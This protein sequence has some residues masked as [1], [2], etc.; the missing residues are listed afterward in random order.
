[1]LARVPG[2]AMACAAALPK[3]FPASRAF[4]PFN[5][6][7]RSS[8]PSYA[9]SESKCRELRQQRTQQRAGRP[10]RDRYACSGRVAAR[11]SRTPGSARPGRSRVGASPTRRRT[12]PRTAQVKRPSHTGRLGR[13]RPPGAAPAD[14][15]RLAGAS[16][17]KSH[18]G[19]RMPSCGSLY[20][21]GE[22]ECA[23][24]RARAEPLP[25][26]RRRQPRARPGSGITRRKL[27]A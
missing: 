3:T 13:D 20:E 24:S 1:M 26:R 22:V 9:A 25:C 15:R 23:A 2:E 27:T 19:S 18:K 8:V 6:G 10:S 12:S 11:P 5:L 17:T 14:R 16:S 21:N 4:I 7:R